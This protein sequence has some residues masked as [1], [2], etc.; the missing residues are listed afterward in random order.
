MSLHFAR[1]LW[2]NCAKGYGVAELPRFIDGDSTI[3]I[4]RNSGRYF[5]RGGGTPELRLEG[6]MLHRAPQETEE[7]CLVPSP[8]R[9]RAGN[10]C[11]E[12]WAMAEDFQRAQDD[13]QGRDR[14]IEVVER[15]WDSL[16]R[17]AALL[18]EEQRVRCNPR[19]RLMEQEHFQGKPTRDAISRFIGTR[20]ELQAWM[21]PRFG[22]PP[23]VKSGKLVVGYQHVRWFEMERHGGNWE[24]IEDP[25]RLQLP[26]MPRK[27]SWSFEEAQHYLRG[28]R[29]IRAPWHMTGI[30]FEWMDSEGRILAR[31]NCAALTILEDDLHVNTPLQDADAEYLWEQA[32]RSSL[33]RR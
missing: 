19:F 21:T 9:S 18:Q 33:P 29:I 4:H 28:T 13:I 14:K 5:Y 27:P 20:T 11:A 10:L 16:V 30:G 23:V 6:R 15:N 25:F 24:K 1:V 31:G 12:V 32:D 2:F 3:G 7:I 8:R 22:P 26:T 17:H